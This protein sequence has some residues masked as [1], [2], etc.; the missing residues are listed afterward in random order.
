M[1]S[2]LDGEAIAII[3][4]VKRFNQYLYVGVFKLKMDHKPFI[5]IFS[6]ERGYQYYP[7]GVYKDG[8]SPWEHTI[9]PFIIEKARTTVVLLP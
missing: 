1:Y 2:Q 3:F 6:E 4:G 8:H 7:R 9:I 5:H